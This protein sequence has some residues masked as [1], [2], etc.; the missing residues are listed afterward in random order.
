MSAIRIV[1]TFDAEKTAETLARVLAAETHDVRVS[2]G[3]ASLHELPEARSAQEAVILIW[4]L[5]ARG[6]QYMR[7]WCDAIDPARLIELARAPTW[8]RS[9]RRAGH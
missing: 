1:C 9:K 8:P 7:D 4:T 2:M 6:A 3:R 5:D